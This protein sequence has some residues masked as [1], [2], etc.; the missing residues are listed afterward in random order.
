MNDKYKRTCL[1]CSSV[2]YLNPRLGL[3]WIKKTNGGKFCS[4][5]CYSNNRKGVR[6]SPETEFKKGMT[7]DKSPSWKGG[8]TVT[9]HGYIQIYRPEHP[10][11]NQRGYIF[12]HRIVMERH[13]GRYL[14][15]KE[16]VHHIDHN[17]QNND[18]SNLTLFNSNSEH[19]K[20]EVDNGERIYTN[21]GVVIA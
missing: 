20:Y 3:N 14:E 17:P 10:K 7:K 6:V 12:E 13:I 1:Y 16:V 8:R 4:H 2:F 18:I 15:R 5:K 19:I 11:C 21:R 9:E